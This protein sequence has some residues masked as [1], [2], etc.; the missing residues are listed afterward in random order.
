[1]ASLPANQQV[2]GK[3][4]MTAGGGFA[5]IPLFCENK[6]GWMFRKNIKIIH[7][8]DQQKRICVQGRIRKT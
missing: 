4:P 1:M 3:A 5:V 7:F 8:C 6:G 2:G